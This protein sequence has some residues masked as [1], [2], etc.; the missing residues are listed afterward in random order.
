MSRFANRTYSQKKMDYSDRLNAALTEYS[1]ILIVEAD[2]VLSD[3]M[4]DVR[5]ALRGK[6]VIIMGKNTLIRKVF[7]N[8]VEK[9]PSPVNQNLADAFL[10]GVLTGNVG[11]VLTNMDINAIL[12]I[13]AQFKVNAAARV[14]AI[15]PIT[16]VV[17]AGKTGLEPTQTHFFM[18]LNIPTKIEGGQVTILKDVTVVKPGDKVGPSEA[19][20]LLKMKMKPFM[21]GLETKFVYDDGVMFPRSAVGVKDDAL[22]G[23]IATAVANIAAV[24]LETGLTTPPAVAHVVLGAFKDILAVAVATKTTFDDFGA[25]SFI[26]AIQEGKVAA[27]APAAAAAGGGAAAAKPAEKKEEKKEEEENTDFGMDLF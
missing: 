11:L 13:L 12:D 17:P 24:S 6:A 21:Y 23:F 2:N 15:A 10:G 9:D 19:K 8:R 18:A 5:K 7:K 27:A 3:Q 26:Q 20:L 22:E 16:V 14:G 1:R 4:H 25:A